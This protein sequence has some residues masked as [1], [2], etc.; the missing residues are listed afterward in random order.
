MSRRKLGT[1]TSRSV[2]GVADGEAEPLEDAHHLVA[3]RADADHPLH[4]REPEGDA[5]ARA[6]LGVDVEHPP[7]DRAAAEIGHELRGPV[8]GRP[9]A[10]DVAAALEAVGGVGVQAERAGRPADPAR[11]P[12]RGLEEH[13]RRPARHLAVGA[14]H[15]SP[16]PQRTV[17]VAHHRHVRA[18]RAHLPVER[19]DPLTRPRAPHHD[20]PPGHLIVVEGVQR[21]A[22]LPHHVVRDVD[23]VIDRTEAHGAQPL[24]EPWRRGPDRQ[25]GDDPRA[26]ARAQV[27]GL[28]L[29]GGERGGLG[30]PF[31][32]GHLG[33]AERR[34]GEGGHLAGHAHHR[35]RIRPI[36]GDLDLED[37]VVE[38]EIG[39]EIGAE[40]R[41]RRERQDAVVVGPKA[42][43]LL[44]TE[45]ALGDDAPDRR[46]LDLAA[47]GQG[48]ARRRER[49]AQARRDVRRAADHRE[50]A[51][52]QRD[53][54]EAVPMAGARFVQLRL[55]GLDLADHDAGE[56]FHDR[57]NRRDFHS[58]IDEAVGDL[59]RPEVGVDELLQPAAGD[60]H[61]APRPPPN[62][63]RK[64]RS[65]SKKSRMSSISYLRMATRSTPIPKAHP[66]TSSG[67]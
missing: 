35:Q 5:G 4:A 38:A 62:C 14:A 25:A 36:R 12:V 10:V 20:P 33:K 18:E 16:N 15:D 27:G 8:E 21:L 64:R 26:E 46:R 48:C 50:P 44:G 60:L 2:A 39:R 54:A 34:A 31:L 23:Q 40:G 65:L 6:R 1:T 19:G 52:R 61:A 43:L 58:R 24:G 17:G 3:R 28:D 45:H 63:C 51:V 67:S 32:H 11:I 7:R 30:L 9:Q 57:R 59:A 42:E 29:D 49:R 41:I 47:P 53:A 22:Q 66:V 55:D 13:G 37:R 56:P